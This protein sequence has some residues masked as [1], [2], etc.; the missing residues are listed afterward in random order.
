VKLLLLLSALLLQQPQ[1]Q[2][3]GVV[4]GRVLFRDGTPVSRMTVTLST[5]ANPDRIVARGFIDD[6][7]NYS[8]QGV[9]EGEYYVR[10][11]LPTATLTYPGVTSDRDGS[12]VTVARGATVSSI[13]IVIP[14][15]LA[16]VRVSGRVT[17]PPNQAPPL[18]TLV[19]FSGQIFK[20]VPLAAD[21]T[22]EASH[23]FAGA[24]TVGVRLPGVEPT[25]VSV[26][27]KDV[28]GLQIVVPQFV[29]INGT[30]IADGGARPALWL[31]FEGATYR[32]TA[33]VQPNGTFTT[34]LPEGS[35]IVGVYAGTLPT[36]GGPASP[37]DSLGRAFAPGYYL[38]SFGT[39]TQNLLANPLKVSAADP[40]GRIAM[41]LGRSAGVKVAG[42][43]RV[44]GDDRRSIAGDTKK[45]FFTSMVT[46][47]I[48]DGSL[49]EDGLFEISAMMPGAYIV[50]T[51][52]TESLRSAPTTVV[53]PNRDLS[54]LEL[55]FAAPLE[56]VGRVAVDGN[57][58]SPRF[59]LGLIRG[60]NL[61]PISLDVNG[62]PILSPELAFLALSGAAHMI[63]VEVNALPDGSF[64][65]PLPPGEYRVFPVIRTAD[66]FV[67]S[68]TYG[69]ARL[70]TEPLVVSDKES[71]QLHIGFGVGRANPWRKVSGRVTGF[72]S[73]KGPYRV[74]LTN[75]M[76]ATIETPVNS[77]GTFEFLSV[78]NNI[79][80]EARL[81]PESDVARVPLVAVL[82][83]D[84]DSVQIAVPREREVTIRAAVDGIAPVPTF[85]LNLDAATPGAPAALNSE[86][87]TLIKPEPDGSFKAR[88]PED[89]R[90]VRVS[91][92]P[93][94]YTV[95]SL[96]YGSI[97][98]LKTPVKLTVDSSVINVV[99]AVDPNVPFGNLQ[100]RAT[101]LDPEAR[102]VRLLLNGAASFATFE[103]TLNAGGSFTFSKIPQGVY[104]PTLTGDV[105][106]GF[107][108]PASI[109]VTGRDFTGLEISF[110]K[111]SVMPSAPVEPVPMGATVSDFSNVAAAAG[112]KLANEAGT[113]ANLRTINTALLTYMSAKGGQYGSISDLIS[114]GL[115]D[116]TF[117]N[118]KTGLTFAVI[119]VPGG[120]TALAIPAT[121]DA[122]GYGF[123]S[124]SD[125][126]VRYSP[127]PMLSPPRRSGN[128]VH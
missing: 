105:A 32:N 1:T 38:A 2:P 84:I 120:Y 69:P 121:L 117:M 78:F 102:N 24:Y 87:S 125:G 88:L 3:G 85:M 96:M 103:A 15:S 4:R 7:G 50:N 40:P 29:T 13:D 62:I 27:D 99:F 8:A 58:P 43:V 76:L 20:T 118:V 9:T 57:G 67:R 53:V 106:S 34:R 44:V 65:M 33:V 48:F 124:T 73:N 128:R 12:V 56:V 114:A 101:G 54:G 23:V 25:R 97:D 110:P 90:R 45:V 11:S 47:M 30:V 31:I 72:D 16:G 66:Y 60:D 83:K 115:L 5:V 71:S 95:R 68:M 42:R 127:I 52:V 112:R 37:V 77:D 70:F 49:K 17:F 41:L 59:S 93:L 35:F 80:Y 28:T 6:S 107:L 61:P 18:G 91:G 89:D 46:G 21:G 126:V 86:F 113:V 92:F 94:G 10:I 119:S 104:I 51:T 55:S 123:Y 22:F 75:R 39:E 82:D 26:T 19:E 122:A 79:T 116:S 108:S 100:G 74:A 81:L 98:L 14:D 64:R 109:T 63:S 36:T 111:E